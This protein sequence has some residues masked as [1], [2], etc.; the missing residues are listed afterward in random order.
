MSKADEYPDIASS[1]QIL[2]GEECFVVWVQWGSG[3]SFGHGSGAY[4]EALGIFKDIESAKELADAAENL[5]NFE[6]G[7]P[8]EGGKGY[9]IDTSDGQHFQDGFCSWR[10][11]FDCLESVNIESTVMKEKL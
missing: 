8:N 7:K 3:D 4:S 5:W 6:C 10:G 9:S 2:P 11:Y 1:L